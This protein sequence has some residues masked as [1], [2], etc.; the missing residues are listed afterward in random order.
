V[1]KSRLIV[2]IGPV[3]SGKSTHIKLLYS[4]LKRRGL[5]V[6]MS[7]LKT[8]HILAFIL[9]IFLAK[10]VAGKRKDVFPIRA[11]V[12][13]KPSLF[14]RLFGLWLG[15]DL[16]GITMKFLMEI[17]LPMKLGYTVLVEEYIPATISDYIYIAE[18]IGFPFKANSL[19]VNYLLK[20]T[21]L[22]NPTQ[23]VFLDADNSNL[24]YRWKLRGSLDEREDYLLMQRTTLLQISKKLTKGFLY[25]DTGTKTIR[26]THKLIM[27]HLIL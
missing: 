15:L 13:E 25:V 22:C 14:K 4:K 24:A 18:I 6:R 2:F 23:I 7:S 21:N 3:G 1:S 26:E 11:L 20:L 17:Y 19:V 10:I 8:G 16:I 12:E 9:E 5:K 27:D